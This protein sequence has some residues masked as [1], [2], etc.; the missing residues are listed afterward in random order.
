MNVFLVSVPLLA[1]GGG[2]NFKGFAPSLYIQSGD[3]LA[4]HLDEI[5]NAS[6]QQRL[7]DSILT[8]PLNARKIIVLLSSP[9]KS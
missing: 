3:V 8:L 1:L 4:V 6:D 2:S 9:Q 7:I 5:H